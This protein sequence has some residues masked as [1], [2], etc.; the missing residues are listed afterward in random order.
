MCGVFFL[1][2]IFFLRFFIVCVL[3]TCSTGLP[4][5]WGDVCDSI[6]LTRAVTHDPFTGVLGRQPRE[7]GAA[8]LQSPFP[9]W[10]FS[11]SPP[12]SF[13]PIPLYAAP[14][15]AHFYDAAQNGNKPVW[16]MKSW[17]PS[18]NIRSPQERGGLWK[19]ERERKPL[20]GERISSLLRSLPSQRGC[21]SHTGR[22][23]MRDPST[24]S[25]KN[26]PG[27]DGHPAEHTQAKS[28]KKAGASA[29]AFPL[30]L[31]K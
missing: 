10:V 20:G 17:E 13:F 15:A 1:W 3:H 9:F 6:C 31:Q 8:R 18:K 21:R 4:D 28:H 22:W 23:V 16:R 25:I 11:P 14:K 30:I 19:R 26:K 29:P 5:A 2:V 7:R 24:Q 12:L 27:K